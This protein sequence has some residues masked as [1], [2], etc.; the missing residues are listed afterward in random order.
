MGVF[1]HAEYDGDICI[2][3][4]GLCNQQI[5]DGSQPPYWILTKNCLWLHI[6]LCNTCTNRFIKSFE[7][8]KPI[9]IYIYMIMITIS[10]AQYGIR[11]LSSHVF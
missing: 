6:T 8:I 10:T 7:M 3:I 2:L 11:P 1:D 5:Q 4:G 9:H